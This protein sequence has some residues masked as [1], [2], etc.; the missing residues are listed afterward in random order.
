MNI[1]SNRNYDATNKRRRIIKIMSFAHLK[2]T[3]I[4]EVV[5]SKKKIE[6][7]LNDYAFSKNFVFVKINDAN[8]KRER[9]NFKCHR[10]DEKSR[11]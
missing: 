8:K 4:D 11:E 5:Q 9:Y 6:T 1:E 10:H 3:Y 2:F 7:R